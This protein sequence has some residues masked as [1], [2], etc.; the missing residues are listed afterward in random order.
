MSSNP[1]VPQDLH[2][3]EYARHIL[4]SVLGWPAKGNL[5]LMADCLTA[6]QS[7]RKLLTAWHAHKYMLRAIELA[8]SQGLTIDRLWFMNGEYTNMRPP[9]G[10]REYE[11]IDRERTRQEQSTPEW[12]ESS[13]KAREVLARIAGKEK[14]D[15]LLAKKTFAGD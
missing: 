14:R 2:A 1:Q 7:S 8:K 4:D 12:D 6:I 9:R 13:R 3:L 5:E 10:L 15:E 11:P